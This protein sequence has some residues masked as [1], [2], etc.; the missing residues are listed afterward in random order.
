MQ[1][2]LQRWKR[3]RA[4]EAAFLDDEAEAAVAAAELALV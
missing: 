1:A 4:A 2:A 3:R